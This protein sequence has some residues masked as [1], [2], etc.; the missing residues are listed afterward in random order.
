MDVFDMEVGFYWAKDV[1][2]K[3]LEAHP[4]DPRLQQ[5][6]ADYE[7]RRDEALAEAKS[8]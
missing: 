5:A 1:L 6:L 2:Q 8:D 3:M 7:R 4:G